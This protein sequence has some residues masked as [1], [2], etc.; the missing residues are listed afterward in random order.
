VSPEPLCRHLDDVYPVA[1]RGRG[2][3][4]CLAIGQRWLHLRRWCFIDEVYLEG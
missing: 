2:C 3:E 1:A 4:E